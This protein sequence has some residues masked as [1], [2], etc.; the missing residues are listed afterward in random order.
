MITTEAV[1]RDPDAFHALVALADLMAIP[2]VEGRGMS[3]AN[4]PK[5]HPLYLGGGNPGALLKQA[6]LIVVLA[7]RVPFYPARNA[8]T[9]KHDRRHQRQSAQGV[10]GLSGSPRRP[11]SRRRRRL[12]AAAADRGADARGRQRRTLSGAPDALAQRARQDRGRAARRGSQGAAVRTGRSAHALRAPARDHAGRY[13]LHRRDR[14]LRQHRAG[15]PALERAAEL[16]PHADRAR[17]GARHGARR[18][19]CGARPAGGRAHR[20]RLVSVQSRR[21]PPSAPRRRTSSRSS[22]SSSTI[23]NTNR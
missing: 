23:A 11:L 1:G 17:P 2:V 15:A 13:D 14:G 12:V 18:Q 9:D 20:R 21:S 22:R 7:S 8:P 5:E 3:H 10:H 19:A 4:F 16:L 6:D